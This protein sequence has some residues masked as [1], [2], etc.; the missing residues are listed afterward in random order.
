M[1]RLLTAAIVLAFLTPVAAPAS[2]TTGGLTNSVQGV[3][4]ASS[5]GSEEM[6]QPANGDCIASSIWAEC[7]GNEL[8]D[9]A[10]VK[11]TRGGTFSSAV[12]WSSQT[13]HHSLESA[14]SVQGTILHCA[15][16]TLTAGTYRIAT[17]SNRE[18]HVGFYF[19][20][21]RYT[22]DPDGRFVTHVD[23]SKPAGEVHLYSSNQSCRQIDPTMKVHLGLLDQAFHAGGEMPM[24]TVI[25]RGAT[26]CVSIAGT[27]TLATT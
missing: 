11:E 4:T 8:G 15:P 14:C 12:V 2:V 6:E 20:G 7:K 26:L 27:I 1:K 17:A 13:P 23:L 10:T 5:I 16:T 19:I 25:N 3:H 22:P 9:A 21:G 18:L 24:D